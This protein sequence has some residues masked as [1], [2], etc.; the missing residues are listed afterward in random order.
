VTNP[1]AI[2]SA[3]L[4]N[5]PHV[6]PFD[7]GQWMDRR[8]LTQAQT[9]NLQSEAQ[10]NQQQTQELA[11]KNQQ[12]QIQLQLE[13][14]RRD[15]AKNWTRSV[16]STPPPSGFP[17]AP[18]PTVT[19]Y[20]DIGNPI[21]APV[22]AEYHAAM[23]S[24]S[25]PVPHFDWDG[26]SVGLMKKG[27]PEGALTAAKTAQA[28]RKNDLD[29]AKQELENH[30][31]QN[32][33]AGQILGGLLMTAQP[34]WKEGDMSIDT[35]GLAKA[36][37]QYQAGKQQLA[38][39]GVPVQD[40]FDPSWAAP[41]H[42]ALIGRDKAI[43]ELNAIQSGKETEA[44]TRLKGA[45]ADVA[46][47]Q[48]EMTKQAVE[49][50]K[51]FLQHPEKTLGKGGL[52]DQLG[53]KPEDA[54]D[55]THEVMAIWANPAVPPAKKGEEV[56]NAMQQAMKEQRDLRREIALKTDPSVL[57]AQREN[58]IATRVGT[59]QALANALNPASDTDNPIARAVAEYRTPPPSPRNLT[60]P[61]G[62]A[63]MK[64]VLAIN[65]T[66]DSTNYQNRQKTRIAYTTGQQGQQ[67][68]QLNTMIGHV[69]DAI[70][71]AAAMGNGNFTPGNA[72]W[73]KVR[74][75]FG[76]DAVT[77][78]DTFKTAVA[79]ETAKVMKG[80]ATDAE[81]KS[82]EHNINAASSPAQLQTALK[83]TMRIAGSKLRGLEY[84]YS[85]AFPE[86]KTF[87]ILSPESKGTLTKRGFD[88]ETMRPSGAA[89]GGKIAVIAPD[90]TPGF[91]DADKWDAAQKRGFKK[92]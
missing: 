71:A 41:A 39:L 52:I 22:P 81:V 17:A 1:N 60:T 69:D 61:Q 89:P 11:L 20:D 21:Y 24:A 13:Q 29:N 87:S 56:F 85:Q 78:F 82:V 91:I 50:T 37:A 58:E 10:L 74:T 6:E 31:A 86:D 62:Q 92:Q 65:P 68:I 19:G 43:Q 53:L 76:S 51:D 9:G 59:Q 16:P 34:K 12:A 64:Q 36:D 48:A 15:E 23:A 57:K 28:L 18:P 42:D 80:V 66:Y 5:G 25:N 40:H 83:D 45:Q 35:D 55:L 30:Q 73:N 75:A 27:D 54:Q 32:S 77:N 7:V 14:Q 46:A 72:L 33:Q 44:S 70:D 84:N 79:G 3:A 26:Y 88:P 38:Q 2:F 47:Q 90:G 67:G 4:A 8:A 49:A 63:F